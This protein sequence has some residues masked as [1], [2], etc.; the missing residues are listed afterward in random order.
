MLV[1][2]RLC[3][4]P[5]QSTRRWF[6]HWW[7]RYRA[8]HGWFREHKFGERQPLASYLGRPG[9]GVFESVLPFKSLNTKCS[10]VVEFHEAL[11]N[12]LRRRRTFCGRCGLDNGESGDASEL[13]WA[14]WLVFCVWV[15]RFPSNVLCP[16]PLA[17]NRLWKCSSSYCDTVIGLPSWS[18]NCLSTESFHYTGGIVHMYLDSTI[19]LETFLDGLKLNCSVVVTTSL[20]FFFDIGTILSAD[21]PGREVN[22]CFVELVVHCSS[23]QECTVDCSVTCNVAYT[24]RG[25]DYIL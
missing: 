6:D 20:F 16:S 13:R 4:L 24:V 12:S 1:V 18:T 2:A 15:H 22:C 23:S 3:L 11:G 17:T 9:R 19:I 8:P 21:L 25:D 7:C 14:V 10:C 5:W